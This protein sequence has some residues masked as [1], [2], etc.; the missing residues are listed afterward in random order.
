MENLWS[1]TEAEATVA[2]YG[3]H[4]IGRDVALRVYTTRLLG[5]EPR[6]VLHGG[7]NT[8]V[9]TSMADL[10][11][12]ETEVLCVKGSGWDMG[13][14][15]PAGLPAVRLEPLRRLR[16]L[17]ALG[18]EDMVNVQR[19]NLLDSTAPNPSV[20]TLLHAF[21]PHA[22]IDHTHA[23]AVLALTDQPDGEA[24]CAELY[25]S[26]AALVPYIMPGFALAKKAQEVYQANPECEGLILLKHGIFSFAEDAEDAYGR[27]IDLVTLAEDRLGTGTGR[28]FASAELP[29]SVAAP[30][31]VAPILRGLTSLRFDGA[32]GR[33][34]PMILEFRT[35][36]AIRDY[37]DGAELG[38]YSQIGPVTPDH[39]I[40][41]KPWPMVVPPPGTEGLDVWAD[42]VREALAAYRV[43]YQAYFERHND[44]QQTPRTALDGM[45]RVVLVPG[46]GLFGLGNS[47]KTAKVAADL[48]ETTVEVISAAERIGRYE[49]IGDADMFDIE[50]WSLEQAKLGRTEEP[51]LARHVAVITGA[52]GAIGAAT[53][54]AFRAEGA[55]VAV[56][57]RDADGAARVA[58]QLGGLGLGCDV[59]KADNVE[60]AFDQVCR[61]FGGVDIVVSN[62]GGAW[63]GR[64]GE[65]ADSV[66]R[67]SFEVNFFA[68]QN[69]ARAAVNVM[70]A[71]GTGGVLLF[72]A[73]KQAVNPGRNFGPYGLPKA[74]TLFLSRQYAVDYG[75]DGIRSN[76]VNADRVRSGLMTETMISERAKARGISER[77]YMA[78]NL[79]HREVLAADVAKAFIDLA[80]SPKTT[81]A[82]LTVDGGNVAAAMR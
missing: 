78:G 34:R 58:Q 23:N 6:L 25:G 60:K 65:V 11:G 77:D 29:G 24:I 41:T 38:R 49:S 81:G 75:A 74:A 36:A 27:M 61:Q 9:K 68:H 42:T 26:R 40:R 1:D 59:T 64:I 62:A 45:P 39:A 79:L 46:L 43:G 55:E 70:R 31:A 48:A 54:K 12:D 80:L 10:L 35:N 53:A 47:A 71:Q 16:A 20:E 57:D 18:D 3:G 5:G 52:A 2:R 44:G 63:Q 21:L 13:D 72:N 19:S 37:V 30:E 69:T 66:L 50:Y 76:A 51:R 14:I 8:S 7:G 56:L 15:E 82:V 32:D 33:R 28:V 73:S 4:G 67:E 22:Y 17:D